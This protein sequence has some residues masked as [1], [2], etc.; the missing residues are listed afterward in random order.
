MNF[1]LPDFSRFLVHCQIFLI[2]PGNTTPNSKF[3]GDRLGF[4]IWVIILLFVTSFSKKVYLPSWQKL[5][6]CCSKSITSTSTYHQSL[7]LFIINA[8]IITII[9]KQNVVEEGRTGCWLGGGDVA[10]FLARLK[11]IDDYFKVSLRFAAPKPQPDN[12]LEKEN[13]LIH[14][15]SWT[16]AQMPMH[17]RSILLG[18]REIFK[19]SAV[20]Q[21]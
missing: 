12:D 18:G 7:S 10:L 20:L 9:V 14:K 6:K 3:Q 16:C 11:H 13:P 5:T 17:T 1:N 8:I 4:D 19:P 21:S 2:W 15:P